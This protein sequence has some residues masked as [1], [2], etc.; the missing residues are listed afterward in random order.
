MVLFENSS[1]FLDHH[2]AD[3]PETVY[4]VRREQKRVRDMGFLFSINIPRFAG[5]RQKTMWNLIPIHELLT[6]LAQWL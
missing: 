5:G 1:Y 3:Y 4:F 6:R 2:P